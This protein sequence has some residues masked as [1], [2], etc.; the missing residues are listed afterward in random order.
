MKDKR[1]LMMIICL[2]LSVIVI[3]VGVTYAFFTY[4]GMGNTENTI[5]TGTL[6]FVYD[7]KASLGN[8][9]SLTNLLPQSDTVGASL[10]GSNQVFDFQVIATTHGSP[11]TYEVI[12]EKGA[13]STLNEGVAKVYL[14]TVEGQT[15]TPVST[16]VK[17]NKVTTYNNLNNTNITNQTGKTIY[18]ETISKNQTNY[19]KV[20]RLRMW[21]SEEA[22]GG[23]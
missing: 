14:T 23:T 11:I 22:I 20:F 1:S 15:E 10:V 3:T 8:G 19:T 13:S 4:V 17:D 18:Q 9:I 21:L 7:E 6:T 16:T 12:A 5:T 2:L